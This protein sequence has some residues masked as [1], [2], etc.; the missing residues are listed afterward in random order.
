MRPDQRYLLAAAKEL[1]EAAASEVGG[2]CDVAAW[3][4]SQAL[5]IDR[6]EARKAGC[7]VAYYRKH[8]KAGVIE[9]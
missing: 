9:K 8:L 5:Y 2:L 7:T 4:E 3:L 6:Q 1:R